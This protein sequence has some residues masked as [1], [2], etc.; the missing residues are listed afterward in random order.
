MTARAVAFLLVAATACGESHPPLAGGDGIGPGATLPVPC[1]E[2]ATQA[3]HRLVGEHDGVTTCSYS[4]QTCVGGVWT[5][6][7][8]STQ[9]LVIVPAG[10]RVT[11]A[12]APG[13]N[14]ISRAVPAPR[15]V[16]L[17]AKPK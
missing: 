4:T 2:G 11:P 1:A 3:C 13:Q 10:A 9:S 8:A 5:D 12:V 15:L 6:C 17:E 7:G 14:G 16:Q